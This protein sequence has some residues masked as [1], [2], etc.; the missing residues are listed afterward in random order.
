MKNRI[1]IFCVLINV[2][3]GFI[4]AQTTPTTTFPPP[5]IRPAEPPRAAPPIPM[6]RRTNRAAF[7]ARK[8]PNS[9]Q[10]KILQPVQ[11]DLN[12]YAQFLK[13]PKTGIFRLLPDI[14]CETDKNIVRA[15]QKCLEAIP[16]SSFYSFREKEH[17]TKYLS[18]IRLNNDYLISDGTLSQSFLTLL[19][20]V[21]LE[22]VSLDTDGLDY[23]RKFSAMPE[24]DGAQK[25]FAQFT[26]GV[27]SEDFVYRKVFRAAENMTY[28]LRVIAFRGSLYQ[29]FGGVKYDLLDGD[30]RV[31]LTVAFRIIRKNDDGSLTLLWKELDRREAPKF[32]LKKATKGKK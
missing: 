1:F 30:N 19:G 32:I 29:T 18:D 23:M 25:Q 22:D 2:F 13:Q 17:T 20:D 21:K 12:K 8:K 15:D 28:A 31:D 10:K 24:S 6:I 9:E 5:V 11:A 26:R 27:K 4:F 14:D 3:A 7:P 16:E